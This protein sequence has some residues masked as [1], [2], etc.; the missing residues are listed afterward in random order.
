MPKP[1]TPGEI[2]Y[3]TWQTAM[4]ER[5]P[6]LALATWDLMPF[7][8][9]APWEAAAQAAIA[10]YREQLAGAF[11]LEVPLKSWDKAAQ[12]HIQRRNMEEET[13]P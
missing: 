6:Q 12:A 1:P 9:Q 10:Q 7:E 4:L 13:T 5:W 11:D 2:C 8:E 3:E